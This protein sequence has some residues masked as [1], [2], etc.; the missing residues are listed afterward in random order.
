MRSISPGAA[1][2]R[3]AQRVAHAAVNGLAVARD[4]PGVLWLLRWAQRRRW[5]QAGRATL[6]L[7]LLKLL[8]Q[9]VGVA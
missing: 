7:R 8:K 5:L 1:T 4:E 3:I 6:A 9:Q 2:T